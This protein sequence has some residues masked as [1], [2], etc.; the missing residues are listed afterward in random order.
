MARPK[1]SSPSQPPLVRTLLRIYE[2]LAS[3]KLAVFV[4]SATAFVLA[5]TTYVERDYG[6]RAVQFGIYGS[7]WFAALMALLGVNVLCAALIRYPWKRYQ[8]GFVV[9][10]AGILVLL[11][12]CLLSRISGIDAQMPIFEGSSAHQAFEEVQHIELT[13][14]K[15]SDEEII[16]VPFASG[17][18]SWSTTA[19]SSRGFPGGWPVA[20]EGCCTTATGCG[21]KRSTTAAIR[22]T[23]RPSR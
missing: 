13:V 6:N 20:T 15:G 4:I 10:H 17:P 19:A 12:G 8:T 5:W 22:C 11:G 21:S 7:W 1:L 16:V 9:T 23:S 14:T 18:F 3:L 2:A